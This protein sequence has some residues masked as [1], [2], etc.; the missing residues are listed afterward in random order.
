MNAAE[1]DQLFQKVPRKV[2]SAEIKSGQ[3]STAHGVLEQPSHVI[4]MLDDGSRIT[5]FSFFAH[6]RSFNPAAFVGLSVDEARRLEFA[7]ER[8]PAVDRA[9][10]TS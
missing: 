1:M 7:P 6:E 4:A 9:A 5:L 8:P 2:V 3:G 10:P